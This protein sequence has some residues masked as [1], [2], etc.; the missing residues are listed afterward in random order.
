MTQPDALDHQSP[1]ARSYL[2]GFLLFLILVSATFHSSLHRLS[3]HSGDFQQFL[4]DGALALRTRQLG[5]A[6]PLE[7][8][9]TTRPL[10]MLMAGAP[11][12]AAVSIWWLGHAWMYW[13]TAVWLA[14]PFCKTALWYSPSGVFALLGLAGVGIWSDLSVGQLTGLILFCV[15]GSYEM[16]RRQRPIMGGLLLALSLLVKPLPLLIVAY[17]VSRRRWAFLVAALAWYVSLGPLLLTALFGWNEHINAW[18]WFFANTAAARSPLAAFDHWAA[19]DRHL[20]YLESG[21]SSALIHLL[22]GVP[23]DREGHMVQI[24]SL[25]PSTVRAIWLVLVGIPFVW[26]CMIAVRRDPAVGTS[27]EAPHFACPG[28]G[29]SERRAALPAD[30]AR[31]DLRQMNAYAALCGVML[32]ANPKFISYWLALPMVCAAPLLI[33][34][35]P[36]V[37][38]NH[39]RE[40]PE[41]QGFCPSDGPGPPSRFV[42]NVICLLALLVW[43]AASATVGWP[44]ARA[45][46]SFPAG[47]LALTIANLLV[48]TA[49]PTMPRRLSNQL[50]YQAVAK[51]VRHR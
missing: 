51:G 6:L 11:P 16:D 38:S 23:Y 37:R 40:P 50:A 15:V 34:G 27:S 43:L 44:A 13:Q 49:G 42:C 25:S 29:D 35:W 4:E 31:Y 36:Y 17:Y 7:Y 33:H 1:Q 19:A 12:K 45:A 2:I 18:Q 48:A 28:E 10:F 39:N 46:G 32:L 21:L 5:Q 30:P 14:R 41:G 24:A 47:V 3:S 20:T 26:G 9:P 22:L 8:P